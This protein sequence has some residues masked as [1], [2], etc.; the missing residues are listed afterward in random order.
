VGDALLQGMKSRAPHLGAGGLSGS[1]HD[2]LVFVV[3]VG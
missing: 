2:V 1:G 3:R